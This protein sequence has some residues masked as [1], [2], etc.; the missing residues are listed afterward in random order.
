MIQTSANKTIREY[1]IITLGL[2]VYCFAFTTILVPAEIVP[3]GAGG[4]STLLYY[5]FG[6]H[7]TVGVYYFVVNAIFLALG[8]MLIG[9]KFGIKTIYAILFNTVA[10]SLMQIYIPSDLMGMD[11][12][13]DRLLMAILGGVLAGVGVGT[14]FSQ[15]G[16][17]GGTDIIA[18]IINK[19]RNIS[20]GKVII[21]C[22]VIIVCC[23]YFLKGEVR[24]IV[25]GFVTMGVMGYTI[26]MVLSGSKQSAQVMIFSPHHEKI[27]KAIIRE[28]GRGVS[29]LDGQ[30]GFTGAPQKIVLVVCRKTEQSAVYRVIKSIDPNAFITVGSVMGVYGKGF[31]ALKVKEPVKVKMGSVNTRSRKAKNEEKK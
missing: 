22:D 4:L 29:F 10:L 8:V 12:N 17:S 20:I 13:S 26:D 27:A 3:G 25:Y 7:F 24:P 18:M 5:A 31:E 1:T 19:Y 15:G 16:S 2:I 23:S 21:A 11:P 30:G 6:E 9:P 28:V 14:C